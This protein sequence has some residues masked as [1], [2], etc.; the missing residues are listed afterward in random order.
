MPANAPEGI[1]KLS[2]GPFRPIYLLKW[3]AWGQ[4]SPTMD[5]TRKREEG[6]ENRDWFRG[7]VQELGG[8]ASC[9]FF[10]EEERGLQLKSDEILKMRET[11]GGFVVDS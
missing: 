10:R 8:E 4:P 11:G 6:R 7:F 2:V 9:P 3:Y 1:P 5:R